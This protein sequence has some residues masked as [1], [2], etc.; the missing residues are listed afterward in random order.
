MKHWFN[1]HYKTLI[2]A[3]FLIP[4]I[5]VAIVS[6][7]HVTQWYG[8]SNPVSWAIYLS[9]GIEI[10]A[11]SALA[12]ISANMGK[13]VYF[14]FAIVTLVQFIGNIF[15][16]YSY[17]DIASKSFQDWVGLVSPLLELTGVEPNDF[18]GHKRFLAF[19]AG[20]MLPII[21]LSF[22]H[23][24]VK[25]TEEDRANEIKEESKPVE[26]TQTIEQLKDFV[27]ETT[28][29]HLSEND[30]KK[31]EE[32]LLN[33]P[34]PNEKLKEAAEVYK[35]RG[36]LLA[37]IIKNDEELGLYDEPF[38]NP[39][40]KEKKDEKW[41][42][43]PQEVWDRMEAIEKQREAIHGPITEEDIPTGALANS[44]IKEKMWADEF[45]KEEEPYA[46]PPS[47]FPKEVEYTDE[48][49]KP[50]YE[51]PVP[52]QTIAE[53]QIDLELAEDDISDW[54]STLMDGLEDEEPFFTEDEIEQIF[55]EEPT[56]E[57]I[58]ENFSTIEPETENIF[59]EDNLVPEIEEQVPELF[60]MP[61][62]ETFKI[63]IR[64]IN[65]ILNE[66]NDTIDTE[67]DDLKKKDELEVTP[68]DEIVET[69]TPTPTPTETQLNQDTDSLYWESGEN[70][71]PLV[72]ED[73]P[74]QV[75]YEDNAND[76]PIEE[77]EQFNP[78]GAFFPKAGSKIIPR[79]V[80]NT[81]RRGFR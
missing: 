56:E 48:Y 69:P 25:F 23:M 20:G 47:I 13:K 43:I 22:L 31:L 14:P 4:I 21:S 24:L 3:A 7:S 58:Q 28:R 1:T 78:F 49:N 70:P 26:P 45:Y 38:D 18:V 35:K 29:L 76:S 36:E 9:I 74:T 60:V 53:P 40:I 33:P 59:Q 34:P 63:D 2:V 17:I 54:D 77:S 67:E 30:L 66:V 65:E 41:G 68:S 81:K 44:G 10:A 50:L 39:L 72:D 57:E 11:L 19:F 32:V 73:S 71:I 75:T 64:A 52:T 27:D 12:A 62:E 42:G 8:I 15:F 46:G 61:E 79:N 6:I 5:T 51:N 80:R 16:A 37:D 55:Q